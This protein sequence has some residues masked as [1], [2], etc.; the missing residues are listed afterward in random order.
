[1]TIDGNKLREL[2]IQ[3][4]VSQEKLGLLTNLNKRTIQ[5]A[6]QGHAVALET[7]AFIA[8]ALEVEPKSLKANQMELFETR[9][10]AKPLE[11]GEVVLVP[12]TKG[13]RL[14]NALRQ[15]FKAHTEYQAEPTDN[16]LP[17]L[18]EFAEVINTA[19][20]DPWQPPGA[21][22]E[23]ALATSDTEILRL[24]A[25]A[26]RLLPL[27][28]SAGIKV[29]V[30]TYESW[31]QVPVFDMDEGFM[32]VRTRQPKEKVSNILLVVTDEE[33]SHLTRAPRDHEV[34]TLE[35]P[36]PSQDLDH[37]IPF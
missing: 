16:N 27:L 12:V 21:I 24:Q 17:L 31:Q 5:R 28:A 18:E 9:K 30:A 10:D 32:A 26:N 33:T 14:V 22:W 8:D 20:V 4:G 1:M 19:W 36:A 13:S 11:Q 29:F 35:N 23:R 2:R 15:A 34:F 25:K 3:K 37:E 6:E 7:L